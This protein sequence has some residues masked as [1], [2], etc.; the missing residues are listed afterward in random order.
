MRTGE[1]STHRPYNRNLIIPSVNFSLVNGYI[2]LR[3][4]HLVRTEHFDVFFIDVPFNEQRTLPLLYFEHGYIHCI[5]VSHV[6][7]RQIGKVNAASVY[8]LRSRAY[9]IC[10]LVFGHHVTGYA[11]LFWNDILGGELLLLLLRFCLVDGLVWLHLLTVVGLEIII[12]ILQ[13]AHIILFNVSLALCITHLYTFFL[14]SC[15]L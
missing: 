8:L 9:Y 1:K 10:E 12:C 3:K 11:L 5:Q 13:F 7:I 4:D 6:L 2:D 14:T 15:P